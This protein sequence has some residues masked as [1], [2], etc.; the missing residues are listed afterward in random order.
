[1]VSMA[2]SVTQF[3]MEKHLFLGIY[4][5]FISI[6]SII[7]INCARCYSSQVLINKGVVKKL[8]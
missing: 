5:I 2:V 6:F 1:M 7:L 8:L 3:S 4:V